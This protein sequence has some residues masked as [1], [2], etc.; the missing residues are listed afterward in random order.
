M[1]SSVLKTN[2]P[3]KSGQGL[4]PPN[5]QNILLDKL[6]A[7]RATPD[8]IFEAAVASSDDETAQ[9][10]SQSIQSQKP[11]RRA[12]WLI[13]PTQIGHRQSQRKDSFA[14]SSMSPTTSHPSTPSIETNAVTWGSAST[15]I[16]SRPHTGSAAFGWGQGG[17]WN[18]RQDPPSRLSE[19]LSSPTSTSASG[20]PF[21]NQEGGAL[22]TSP[23]PNSSSNSQIPFAIPIHP[24]P[25][26][27]R[28]QSYSVGQLDPDT[29]VPTTTPG[30]SAMMGARGRGL[31]HPGLQ[32]RPS[33]PSMLSE[34]SNEGGMLGK[35]KE[36]ED[37]DNAY[38]EVGAQ[39]QAQAQL[40]SAEA[41]TIEMLSRENAMLRQQQLNASRR[42]RA[43][44]GYG[45]GLG[46]GYGLR[47][48]VPEESSDFAVEDELNDPDAA[49]RR[50]FQRRM[51]E[52]GSAPFR[53]S[54]T[55]E[56]RPTVE[57]RPLEN[58]KK[59]IWSTSLGFSLSDQ[60]QS[61]RH[62]FADVPTRQP[63]VGPVGDQALSQEPGYTD[64]KQVQSFTAAQFEN[65]ML[66]QMNINSSKWKRTDAELALSLTAPRQTTSTAGLA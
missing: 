59:A 21:L 66:A 31:P 34:M 8:S 5:S 56:T 35:V 3:L 48:P 10:L 45:G 19:V 11:P 49:S 16:M 54:F 60:P 2:Q 63:S 32:H 13:E 37:D 33:R 36:V 6:N 1:S 24:T 4:P 9:D 15:T 27:Y 28:S 61:R 7:R 30:P 44:T 51:S 39:A 62:S 46:N 12:S 26:N 55:L 38:A 43:S 57:N 40:Q 42:P 18:N 52:Y 41:K 14:S 50:G 17:I 64:G 53:S 58:V 25:K 20:N 47:D 23:A 29:S 65:A 22:Q